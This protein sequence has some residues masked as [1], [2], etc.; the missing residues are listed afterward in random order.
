[1]SVPS[2]AAPRIGIPVGQDASVDPPSLPTVATSI[3]NPQYL[4]IWTPSP[5]LYWCAALRA[6]FFALIENLSFGG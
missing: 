1:M 5:A 6:C 3:I 4:H 2:P